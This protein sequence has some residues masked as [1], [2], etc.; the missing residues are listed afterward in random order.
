MM[1]LSQLVLAAQRQWPNSILRAGQ[2]ARFLGVRRHQA[3]ETL[4]WA[5]VYAGEATMEVAIEALQ[6]ILD[7]WE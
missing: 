6:P 2:L 3:V 4:F 1:P 5:G 7:S